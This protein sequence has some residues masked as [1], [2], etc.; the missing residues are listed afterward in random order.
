MK[1]YFAK[2][3]D[4]SP[5]LKVLEILLFLMPQNRWKKA[6]S[7]HGK[8]LPNY[9]V[10]I[11]VLGGKIQCP[12]NKNPILRT[13]KLNSRGKSRDFGSKGVIFRHF[14]SP[15]RKVVIISKRKEHFASFSIKLLVSF[16]FN[17]CYVYAFLKRHLPPTSVFTSRLRHGHTEANIVFLPFFMGGS[18]WRSSSCSSRFRPFQSSSSFQP[19]RW[20]RSF[21]R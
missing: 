14:Y 4:F 20:G 3:K 21:D 9:Q 17:N 2:L 7:R 1:G 8:L 10:E 5:K 11:Q 16:T 12:L 6:W 19:R 18:F 13:Y 15:A